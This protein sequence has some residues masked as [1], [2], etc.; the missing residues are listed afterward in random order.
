MTAHDEE[1]DVRQG[2]VERREEHFA[3]PAEAIA[4]GRA[5]AE[6][7]GVD[8]VIHGP[9]GTVREKPGRE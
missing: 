5:W 2:E 9:H 6:R 1:W 8:L 3:D 4:Q 7:D